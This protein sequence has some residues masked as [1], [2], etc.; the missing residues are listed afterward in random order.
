[1]K[2][3]WL[4][5]LLP[6]LALPLNAD[7]CSDGGGTPDPTPTPSPNEGPDTHVDVF[8]ATHQQFG[9]GDTRTVS[10]TVTLPDVSGFYS[11]ITLNY[12]LSCP[13]GGCDPWDRL[14]YV[15]AVQ[16]PGTPQEQVFELGRFITPYGVG[17]SWNVDVTDLRPV[18]AGDVQIRSFIDTWVNPGWMVD[19]SLDFEGG[20][21]VRRAIEVRPLYWGYYNYGDPNNSP[22]NYL[23]ERIQPIPADVS[24]ATI[25]VLT[26]GHG[27]GATE[28]CAEFCQKEHTLTFNDQDNTEIPWRADCRTAG[29]EGQSGTYW[30]SRA[31]WC[32][33]DE[34]FPRVWDVSAILNPGQTATFDY[35]IQDYV[36]TETT[37]TPYWVMSSYLVLYE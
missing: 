8:V 22:D 19:I 4:A 6:A 12:A 27:F 7:S 21:P 16:N 34:V 2:L 10:A 35:R 30:Y 28:N 23:P 1:M 33:G 17:G 15:Q 20:T 37:V 14:A 26:T 25:R 11:K 3:A 24:G 31:G 36:N 13:T 9:N 18:L 29:V 5:L 32:P